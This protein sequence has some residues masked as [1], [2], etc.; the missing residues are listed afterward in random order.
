MVSQGL[1]W[2]IVLGETISVWDQP[3]LKDSTQ[4]THINELQYMWDGLTVAH[5][6]KLNTKQWDANFLAM[7]SILENRIRV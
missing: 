4:L 2:S 1:H 3:W 6:F 5:L 7:F